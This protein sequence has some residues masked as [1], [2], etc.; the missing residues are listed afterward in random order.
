MLWRE[1]HPAFLRQY[2]VG[3]RRVTSGD[4]FLLTVQRDG[5]KVLLPAWWERRFLKIITLDLATG[6]WISKGNTKV[7]EV[8]LQS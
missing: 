2:V 8:F 4:A 5:G 1:L 7:C 6:G 3:R